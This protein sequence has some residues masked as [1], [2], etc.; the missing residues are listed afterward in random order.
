MTQ[1]YEKEQ[2][3][4]LEKNAVLIFVVCN[5][6]ALVRDTVKYYRTENL[7]F[8]NWMLNQNTLF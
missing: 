1:D 7:V 3:L 2:L 8:Q 6:Y 5:E 4:E